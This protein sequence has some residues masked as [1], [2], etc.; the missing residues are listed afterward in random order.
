MRILNHVA[1]RATMEQRE[2]LGALGFE[3][4][5]CPNT[6]SAGDERPPL[7][8]LEADEANPNWPLVHRLLKEWDATP[9]I[10]YTEFTPVNSIWPA[11][12]A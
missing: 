2:M 5:D 12:Y 8:K 11:I 3:T 4:L 1:F 6:S 7:I 9:I 10:P